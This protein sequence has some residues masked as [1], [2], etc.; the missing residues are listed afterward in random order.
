M[1]CQN[2]VSGF[3]IA[4]DIPSIEPDFSGCLNKFC[5][6]KHFRKST[7]F[8]CFLSLGKDSCVYS[9]LQLVGTL[10]ADILK[11]MEQ[12][13][14]FYQLSFLFTF[15]WIYEDP[16]HTENPDKMKALLNTVIVE[17]ADYYLIFNWN[18][19]FYTVF[20]LTFK[21]L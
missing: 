12:D 5:V 14:F 6:T 11:N 20:G 9:K 3:L 19:T 7:H 18:I 10:K 4:E 2:W 21:K 16:L 13:S 17:W 8:I 15:I 1:E